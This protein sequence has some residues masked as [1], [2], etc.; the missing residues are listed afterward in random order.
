MCVCV[1]LCVCVCACDYR[2]CM[3]LAE[4]MKNLELCDDPISLWFAI[5]IDLE[6][7][8][9]LYKSSSAKMSE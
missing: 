9:I 1:C 2:Y 6:Q 5:I 8:R 3:P 7:D 4:E